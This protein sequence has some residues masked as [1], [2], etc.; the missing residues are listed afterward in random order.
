[1]SEPPATPLRILVVEDEREVGRVFADF[2]EQI[3]HQAEVVETA[4]AALER[5]GAE[6]PHAILLDVNLPG[7]SGL[8]F[9]A[10]PAVRD[11]CA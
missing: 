1:M 9:M 3:G 7:M 2:L 10:L 8:D 4:E 11:P 6:V 5:M